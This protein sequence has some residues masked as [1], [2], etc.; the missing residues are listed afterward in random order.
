MLGELEYRQFSID[1][2]ADCVIM[3]Q[4]IRRDSDQVDLRSG[5]TPLG[6]MIVRGWCCARS[7]G[8]WQ[9]EVFRKF[10]AS[11][12]IFGYAVPDD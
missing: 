6:D 5:G 10:V 12:G 11:I 1:T 7:S 8:P 3:E 2:A 9:D 4:G